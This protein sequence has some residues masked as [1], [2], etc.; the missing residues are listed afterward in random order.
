MS[1]RLSPEK[2]Q[3]ALEIERFRRP[4]ATENGLRIA[5]I[6][7]VRRNPNFYNQYEPQAKNTPADQ[8]KREGRARKAKLVCLPLNMLGACCGNCDMFKPAGTNAPRGHCTH[9]RIDMEVKHDEHCM[10]WE[11]PDAKISLQDK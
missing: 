11:H 4:K 9:P 3:Q 8:S 6:T 5:V 1:A 10:W 7:Q 2:F